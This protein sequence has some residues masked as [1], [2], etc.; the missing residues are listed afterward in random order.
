MR[1]QLTS[2]KICMNTN[3]L[4][5]MVRLISRLISVCAV[6]PSTGSR[7]K[8][9]GPRY[10]RTRLTVI[11]IGRGPQ[12][13]VKGVR[14]REHVGPRA[15]DFQNETRTDLE[16]GLADDHAPHQERDQRLRLAVRRAVQQL[17]RGRLGGERERGHGVHDQ[18]HPEELHRG[19]DRLAL[20]V[21][22]GADEGERHGRLRVQSAISKDQGFNEQGRVG[23]VRAV[24]R[25]RG[26]WLGQEPGTWSDT[27]GQT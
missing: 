24:D 23:D 8:M 13:R 26:R 3:V 1:R 6:S 18:V 17:G 4:N 5:T 16:N 9:V 14:A 20:G 21:R 11:W 15:G 2:L 22:D 7:L 25:G 10:R 19:Q 27:D 12:Y